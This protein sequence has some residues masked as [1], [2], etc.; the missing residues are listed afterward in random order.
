MS[1]EEWF[2]ANTDILALVSD[3]VKSL[4]EPRVD[5]QSLDRTF[6]SYGDISKILL[7]GLKLLADVHPVI[8]GQSPIIV[9]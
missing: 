8:Q 1:F 9:A 7:K 4:D 5:I 6:A 3:A 2:T